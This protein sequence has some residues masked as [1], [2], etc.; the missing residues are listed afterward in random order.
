MSKDNSYYAFLD[1]NYQK[2]GLRDL[3]IYRRKQNPSPRIWSARLSTGLFGLTNCE[4]GNRGPKGYNE[5]LLAVGDAGLR[6]LVDLGFITCPSCRPEKIESFWSI[7]KETVQHKYSI[8]SL[9]EFIDKETLP[10]DA[11]RVNWE[12]LLPV[13]GKA[14]SRLYLPKGL[15]ERDLIGLKR[16]FD[17]IGINLPPVGYYNPNVAEKF[18]P[19]TIDEK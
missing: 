15:E 1:S 5:V 16:R 19:Y 12:E 13:I 11:R 8:I 7:L 3:V 14:P 10:F 9:E 2:I 4:A 17:D 6:K 18:T